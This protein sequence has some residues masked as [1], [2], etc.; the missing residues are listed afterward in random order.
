ML[1]QEDL[2]SWYEHPVTKVYLSRLK[3]MAS[4]MFSMELVDFTQLSIEEIGAVGLA[5][6]NYA[7]ALL[8]AT[9]VQ[10]VLQEIA[11]ESD[12]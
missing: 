4:D 3:D 5:K 9:D 2:N 6:A 8:D 1:T 11:D 10:A 12:D 7:A